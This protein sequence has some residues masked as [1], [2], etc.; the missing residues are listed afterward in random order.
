MERRMRVAVYGATGHTGR[1]VVAELLRRGHAPV[2][3]GRNESALDAAVAAFDGTVERR[4]AALDSPDSLDRAL[5]DADA[6]VHCAGPF[7]DTAEPLIEAALRTRIHYFDLAAEQGSALATFE[8][9]DAPARERGIA[10]VPAAGFYGGLGDLLATAAMHG[11]ADADLIEIAIALDSWWPT[12]GT[13]RTGERNVLPRVVFSGGKLEQLQSPQTK[14]WDFREPFGPQDV[15][16]VPLTETVLI[17]RHLRTREMR[18]F[19]NQTPLNDL[20]DP[21][22]PGPVAVDERGRSNQQ[23]LVDVIARS[24]NEEHR[25]A[26]AGRDIY[27]VTAPIVVE[28]VERVCT[29]PQIRAGA[30]ALGQLIDARDFLEKLA[31]S[32]DIVYSTCGRGSL[33]SMP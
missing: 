31:A 9:F 18:N 14:S 28:A 4:V 29:A 24:G 6:V 15:L 7:L 3:L 2:A 11:F 26:A 30:F 33:E 1:F 12:E 17:A 5:G 21:A 32:G 20:S 8:R 13:R 23:F 10:I 16:E 27:A 25:V 19:I 22:T